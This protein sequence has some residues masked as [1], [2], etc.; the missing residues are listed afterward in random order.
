MPLVLDHLSVVADTLR[1]RMLAVLE[2]QELTVSE[3]CSVLQL[4]QSTVSRHLKILSDAGWAVSRREG[5]SRLYSV[6]LDDFDPTRRR[7]WQIVQEQVAATAEALQDE[8]RLKGVLGERR[9]KSEEFFSSA[10]G[11]WDRVRADLFGR[12]SHLRPLLGLLD[13]AWA[14]GDLGCGTGPVAE[15]LAPFVR[16]V[17][18]IDSSR[19]MLHAARGRLLDHQ[20]ITL[21]RATLERLPLEEA[22]LDAAVIILVLHHI[23]DPARVLAEA[24]RVVVPG[25]RLLVADMLP[26]EHDEYRQTMGHVWLGFSERQMERWLAASGFTGMRWHPLA[27]EPGVKGPSL[28]V[29]TATRIPNPE[30]ASARS[31]NARRAAARPRRSAESC[32]GREDG[33]RTPT[34]SA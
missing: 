19:E 5:T 23:A 3:L 25:G 8:A 32:S 9:S 11:Q 14:V 20:N 4:P 24:A 18:A 31:G 6:P 34:F 33:S 13:P 15:A 29:A 2:R 10:A 1:A 28:F 27:V 16:K 22:E 21:R 26:H 7:L 17:V 30:P 12:D